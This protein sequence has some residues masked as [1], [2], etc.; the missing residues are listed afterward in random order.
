MNI[1]RFHHK[2]EESILT[3]NKNKSMRMKKKQRVERNQVLS[4]LGNF[5]EDSS[6]TSKE[7]NLGFLQ[8]SRM[9][10]LFSVLLPTSSSTLHVWL[11]LLHSEVRK[12]INTPSLGISDPLFFCH[13]VVRSTVVFHSPSNYRV[14]EKKRVTYSQTGCMSMHWSLEINMNRGILLQFQL[15]LRNRIPFTASL[16]ISDP[17]FFCHSVVRRWVEDDCTSNYRVTEKKGVT[18]SQ[19][20]CNIKFLILWVIKQ[21]TKLKVKFINIAMH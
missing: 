17:L 7:K 21:T 9:H 14:S 16:G 11:Q 8:T 5:L 18:Y 19:T 20:G 4:G 12:T 15:N 13:S 3:R 1:F 10:F 2:R 6:M